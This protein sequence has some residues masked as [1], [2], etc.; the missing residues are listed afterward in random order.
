VDDLVARVREILS[1]TPER[2]LALTAAIDPARLAAR[3]APDQWSAAE[4]L[5][6]ILD[7]ELG[8]FSVRVEA[9][10]AGRDLAAFDPDAED[11]RPEPGSNPVDLANRF[12]QA[13]ARSLTALERLVEADLDRTANHAEYGIV[14]MREMLNEWAA[15]DLMHTVQ[16]ERAL[17]QP[18]VTGSGKWRGTFADHDVE[19]R[20]G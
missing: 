13:R 18:F 3:P 17:M 1:T 19:A 5:E 9:F 8:A 16:A 6:H 12:A 20:R 2:W 11:F 10:M 15:H 7:T 14:T 4:C